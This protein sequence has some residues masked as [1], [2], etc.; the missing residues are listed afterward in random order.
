M[1]EGN[2]NLAQHLE[3]ILATGSNVVTPVEMTAV[4]RL[5]LDQVRL[6]QGGK[7]SGGVPARVTPSLLP[8]LPP[9][10]SAWEEERRRLLS[11]GHHQNQMQRPGGR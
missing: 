11:A 3:L 1:V 10:D 2:W 9:R 8:P 7:G 5:Q 4:Q 6:Q